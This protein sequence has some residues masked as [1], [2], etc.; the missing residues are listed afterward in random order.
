MDWLVR[1]PIADMY[2]P[3]FLLLYAAVSALTLILCRRALRSADPTRWMV[4]PPVPPHPDPYELAYLRGGE[5]ELVRVVVLGLIQRGYLAASEHRKAWLKAGSEAVVAQAPRPP[6]PRHLTPLERAVFDGFSSPKSPSEMFKDRALPLRLEPHW[7]PYRRRLEGG[8][9]LMPPEVRGSARR[10]GVRGALV[11]LGLGGYKL[12]TAL[13]KGRTNVGFLIIM[14]ILALLLLLLLGVGGVP[15]L[16]HK[17]RQY[18]ERAQ[19]AFERLKE[20]VARLPQ[21]VADHTLLLLVGLFGLGVLAG[22]PYDYYREIFRRSEAR[23]GS[24]GTGCGSCGGG[25]GDG[26]GGCGGCGGC[27]GG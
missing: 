2:G 27:G 25:G 11:I 22:T 24:C 5:N 12:A 15:R 17:G 20:R 1:N 16:S 14:G 4:P 13:G 7:A 19:L 21:A 10:I 23:G 6:D 9:L 18:L 26:G 8:R 3:H